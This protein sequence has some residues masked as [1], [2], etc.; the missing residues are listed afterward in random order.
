V[1]CDNCY[2]G[3][4]GRLAIGELMLLPSAM[5]S[6]ITAHAT[7]QELRQWT[8]TR[9]LLE[10]GLIHVREGRTTLVEILEAAWA[11]TD[12]HLPSEA[13]RENTALE[14]SDPTA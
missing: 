6:K 10:N 9:T 13:I 2:G 11:F 7:E 3:Y 1:G 14:A 5:R 8:K 12:T 4:A